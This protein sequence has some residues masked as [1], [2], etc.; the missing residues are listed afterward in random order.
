MCKWHSANDL[1]TA[2]GLL[3]CVHRQ[4]D[5]ALAEL[6]S[7][8]SMKRRCQIIFI[9]RRQTAPDLVIFRKTW[10]ENGCLYRTSATAHLPP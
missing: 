8:V 6:P 9:Q 7:N 10:W 5:Q 4:E 1:S 2:A 3:R